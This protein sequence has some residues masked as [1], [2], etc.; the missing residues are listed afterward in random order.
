MSVLNKIATFSEG[1]G[2]NV[3]LLPSVLEIERFQ[4]FLFFMADPVLIKE[5]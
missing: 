4:K 3:T 5:Y 1:N 2:K